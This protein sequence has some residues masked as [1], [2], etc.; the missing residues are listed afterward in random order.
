M[1]K[2]SP[3]AES[4]GDSTVGPAEDRAA[5]YREVF[6]VREFRYLFSAYLL[7]LVGDQLAKVALSIIVFE[8]TG[9]ALLSAVTFAVSYLPWLIGGPLLSVYADRHPRRQVMIICDL[10]RMVLV[11]SLALPGM[12][13]WALVTLLFIS[14]LFTPPFEAARAATTPEVLSGDKYAVGLAMSSITAQ[15]AQAIG[16]LA[17]G[18]LVVLVSARGSL[19]IDAATF[20]VSAILLRIG[21]RPR[22]AASPDR[23]ATLWS[24]AKHGMRVVFGIPRVR[25]FILMLFVAS[26]FAYAPEGLAAA[27]AAELGQGPAAVGLLL[28]AS[29]LGLVVGGVVIGRMLRPSQ[30]QALLVPL[31]VLSV[32]MLIPAALVSS[33]PVILVLFVISGFGVSFLIPLNVM[34]VEA[35]PPS[36]RARAFGV[37][38]TGLQAVQGIAIVV[39][40]LVADLLSPS[41][42]VSLCGVVGTAAVLWLGARGLRAPP[43]VPAPRGS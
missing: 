13:L 23:D 42:V 21:V 8:R 1:G 34:V 17:G 20:A 2:H 24:D 11:G 15:L 39:A 3:T 19:L 4:G 12:P 7:S 25:W 14:N 16:F 31:A 30:R 22:P 36:T 38:A 6:A 41:I 29:P 35:I 10:I 9:S 28:A 33:L 37:V 32:V 40:G 27:Y 43:P 26:A 18:A 5:T